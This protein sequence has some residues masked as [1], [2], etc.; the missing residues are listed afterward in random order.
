MNNQGI[1]KLLSWKWFVHQPRLVKLSCSLQKETFGRACS[2][3]KEISVSCKMFIYMPSSAAIVGS[4]K[5]CTVL[6]TTSRVSYLKLIKQSYLTKSIQC[7]VADQNTSTPSSVLIIIKDT[8]LNRLSTNHLR[9][10]WTNRLRSSKS[11]RP[12]TEPRSPSH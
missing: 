5:M 3:C 7:W 8:I 1:Q 2:L 6:R 12:G 4:T 11:K 10:D 9:R